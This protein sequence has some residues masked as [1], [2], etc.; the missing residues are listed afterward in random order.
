LLRRALCGDD[1]AAARA[2]RQRARQVDDEDL[3]G[4]SDRKSAL[5]FP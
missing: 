3:Q 2:A 4:P 5:P 1:R